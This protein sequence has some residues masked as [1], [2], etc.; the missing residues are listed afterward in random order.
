MVLLHFGVLVISR[1]LMVLKMMLV[2][3][4]LKMMLVF[5]GFEAYA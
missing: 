4:D 1:I 2:F 5:D 3:D